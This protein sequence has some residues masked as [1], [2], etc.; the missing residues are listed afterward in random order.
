[1]YAENL[2]TMAP[3]LTLTN[4]YASLL[5]K[6]N[7]A[8][9]RHFGKVFLSISY[10]YV[11]NDFGTQNSFLMSFSSFG[12]M[13]MLTYVPNPIWRPSAILEKS[14]SLFLAPFAHVIPLMLLILV[15]RINF[16]CYFHHWGHYTCLFTYQIQ[17]GGCW[18]Y[19]T[20][21]L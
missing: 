19:W 7:M 1:M 3:N 4:F 18:L 20:S 9:V 6:S 2:G 8:V 5:T 16:C 21:H 17:Y 15:C 14:S 12:L 11:V 13:F 10:S